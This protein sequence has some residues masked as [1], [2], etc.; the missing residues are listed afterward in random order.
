M[1]EVLRVP[2]PYTWEIY[3][4]F[5]ADFHDCFRMFNPVTGPALKLVLDRWLAAMLRLIE[6]VPTHPAMATVDRLQ[7]AHQGLNGTEHVR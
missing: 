3:G 2:M 7:A 1:F 5:G 4:D 6:L